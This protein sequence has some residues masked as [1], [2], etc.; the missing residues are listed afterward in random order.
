L[1]G[2]AEVVGMWGGVVSG[3][4]NPADS[5]VGAPECAV[6]DSETMARLNRMVDVE[7]VPVRDVASEYLRRSGL[8]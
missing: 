7:R 6:P 3:V 8:I 2:V 4:L 5:G 1:G